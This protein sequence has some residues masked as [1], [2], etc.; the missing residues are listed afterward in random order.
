MIRRAGTQVNELTQWGGR[1]TGSL[2]TKQTKTQFGKTVSGS[3]PQLSPQKTS[4]EEKRVLYG[5]IFE[6]ELS[7]Q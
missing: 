6:G 5:C 2:K 1:F 3:L 4:S 7:I